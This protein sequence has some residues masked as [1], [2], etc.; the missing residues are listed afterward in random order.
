MRRNRVTAGAERSYVVVI[1]YRVRMPTVEDADALGRVH[2]RA[3]RAAYRGGL[4]PDAHLDVFTEEDQAARWRDRLEGSPAPAGS[5]LVATAEDGGV[6]GFIVVG[7]ADEGRDTSVGEVY[8]LNVDPDHWGTG[9]GCDLLA[10]GVDALSRS[11]FP[12]AVLWVHPGNARGTT[13]LRGPRLEGGRARTPAGRA[14]R[15]VPET[16]Y[17]R[18]LC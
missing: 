7:G 10:Y 13:L 1:A 17:S 8:A 14:R 6:V 4:V 15:D 16:R 2:A 5:F 11:G 3:W 9:A 18:A 12:A